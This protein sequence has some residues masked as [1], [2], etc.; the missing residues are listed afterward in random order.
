MASETD[1]AW[2]AGFLE[3]DGCLSLNRGGTCTVQISV[4][5]RDPEPIARLQR[6]FGTSYVVWG[7]YRPKSRYN[8]KG[9]SYH[10]LRFTSKHALD[11]LQK[12]LPY[13]EYKRPHAEAAIKLLERRL[14]YDA[15]CR[16]GRPSARI[17]PAELEA[18]QQIID[19]FRVSHSNRTVGVP[20]Q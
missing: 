15:I 6:I 20:I 2:A 17:D 8:P 18:R 9:R 16:N 13:L 7:A 12:M 11:A 19:A 4:V 1:Y 14:A 10:T 5:Q 3:A